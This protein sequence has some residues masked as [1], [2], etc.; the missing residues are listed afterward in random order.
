MGGSR[1]RNLCVCVVGGERM[2]REGRE[3]E[4]EGR[5][6]EREG[7]KGEREGRKGERE[8]REGEREGGNKDV[9]VVQIG[10]CIN[11]GIPAFH[12]VSIVA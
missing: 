8:G 5:K 9:K 4:R 7:R 3:G 2:G 12:L 6:G 11:P 1:V 10:L